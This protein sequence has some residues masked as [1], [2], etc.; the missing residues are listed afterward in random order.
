MP[1]TKFEEVSKLPEIKIGKYI[2]KAERI[3]ENSIDGYAAVFDEKRNLLFEGEYARSKKNGYGV[4]Y[5]QESGIVYEGSFRD[6]RYDGWG[7]T[8]CY[9]G[10][11]RDGFYDGYGIYSTNAAYYE[12]FFTR[13]LFNG[14]GIYFSG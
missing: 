9:S 5:G 7:R 3:T 8:N 6:D 2:V 11:F 14:E 13:G 4:E 1:E 10:E 12:G